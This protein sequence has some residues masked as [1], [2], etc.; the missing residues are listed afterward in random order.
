MNDNDPWKWWTEWPEDA[1][2]AELALEL[3]VG[4]MRFN[5]DHG[6]DREEAFARA[7]SWLAGYHSECT[8]ETMAELQQQLEDSLP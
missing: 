5:I 2:N 4:G 8:V 3:A 7:S 1:V 6:M